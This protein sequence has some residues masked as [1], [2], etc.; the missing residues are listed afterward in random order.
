MSISAL[1]SNLVND[2]SQQQRQNPFQQIRQD[3]KQLAS[4]LQSGDLPDAQS[5][6]SNI[7][8]V[9][10]ANQ[11]ASGSNSG[12]S[13]S[14]LL[15]GDFSTLGQALQSGNLSQAQ[16][17]FSQLENDFQAGGQPGS[18]A[19]QAA[20]RDQ[21]AVQAAVEDR[22]VPA[23]QTPS[24]VQQVQQEYSQLANALQSGN[25]TNA[26]SAFAALQQA[27]QSQAGTN[28]AS[29][30]ASTTTTT[31]GPIANDLNTLGEALNSGSLTQAQ[32]AFSQL[33]SDVQTAEQANASQAQGLNQPQGTSVQGHHHHHH[34]GGGSDTQSATS[35]TG[36]T[37]SSTTSDTGASVSVYG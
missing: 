13:G 30:P 12:S 19:A 15:Q 32:S 2:L 22:Y 28:G 36:S 18:G 31:S 33:Q 14:N 21:P 16:S 8:Q 26:Q 23:S 34:H 3:F 35:T 7:Q 11:G 6:Y 25:L 20:L 27:L 10:Q 5:A 4:A 1:S 37:A 24:P 9:L 17:A 29:S